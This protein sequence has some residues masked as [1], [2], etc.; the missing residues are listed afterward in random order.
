M[1][2]WDTNKTI[3]NCT[4]LITEGVWVSWRTLGCEES[5]SKSPE[6]IQ[7]KASI[8]THRCFENRASNACCGGERLEP[9]C[10]VNNT[11]WKG[12]L[13]QSQLRAR[14]K[15]ATSG[16]QTSAGASRESQDSME[17]DFSKA[18]TTAFIQTLEVL[19]MPEASEG[20]VSSTLYFLCCSPKPHL[21]CP[22]NVALRLHLR[23]MHFTALPFTSLEAIRR[24]ANLGRNCCQKIVTDNCN[25]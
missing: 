17:G 5:H 3:H 20:G 1:T 14:A 11:P 18:L 13:L 8:K 2:G 9:A 7:I 16:V 15:A 4:S 6:G 25:P 22:C 19:I 10:P 23:G 21:S 12:S 24:K